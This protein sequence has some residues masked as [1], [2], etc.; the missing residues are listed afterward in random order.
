MAAPTG[1]GGAAVGA[2]ESEEGAGPTVEGV[3]TAGDEVALRPAGCF[4]F[5]CSQP[6]SLRTRSRCGRCLAG[7]T[8]PHT[9]PGIYIK[10]KLV[11]N[12]NTI[13]LDQTYCCVLSAVEG[14]ATESAQQNVRAEMA[15][16]LRDVKVYGAE[17]GHMSTFCSHIQYHDWIETYLACQNCCKQVRNREGQGGAERDR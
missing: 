12:E 3:A 11:W 14:Y 4:C 15:T 5:A 6:V 16:Y 8:L 13:G 7:F 10:H 2:A 17:M 9:C 1:A